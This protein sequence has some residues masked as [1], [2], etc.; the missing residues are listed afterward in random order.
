MDYWFLPLQEN[1]WQGNND[2][3]WK[4]ERI[5]KKKKIN[6]LPIPWAMIFLY[7]QFGLCHVTYK[8]FWPLSISHAA[9]MTA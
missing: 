3:Y 1:N 8:W 6:L 9:L 2:P 4:R 5:K 7:N